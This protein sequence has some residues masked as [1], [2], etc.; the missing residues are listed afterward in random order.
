MLII[1]FQA[2]PHVITLKAKMLL[3][4]FFF[5][6]ISCQEMASKQ[7]M[8][9]KCRIAGVLILLLGSIA[10]LVAVAVIQDTWKFKEY[11]LEVNA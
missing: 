3:V 10:A 5:N 2:S 8:G 1:T 9:Y 6:P 4:S 7:K 11:S